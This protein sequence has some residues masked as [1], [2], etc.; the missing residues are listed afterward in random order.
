MEVQII[1]ILALIQGQIFKAGISSEWS[2]Q[3]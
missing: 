3:A 2:N 1:D